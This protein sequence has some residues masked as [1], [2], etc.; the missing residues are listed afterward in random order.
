M[1]GDDLKWHQSDFDHIWLYQICAAATLDF[2]QRLLVYDFGSK[3]QI[4]LNFV[5][6][7]IEPGNDVCWC[8]NLK[9]KWFWQNMNISNLIGRHLGFFPK[10]LAYDF[11]SKFQISS[12]LLYSQIG[13]WN[14]VWWCFRVK[15]KWFWRYM[16]MSDLISRHLGFFSKGVSLW[17]WV[18]ISNFFKLCIWSDWTWKWCLLMF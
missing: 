2:F 5:Y 16:R 17:F 8:F 13:P 3:F 12:E 18:K 10:G 14:H 6:G 4:S 11:G 1:F 15:L 7:E 9:S